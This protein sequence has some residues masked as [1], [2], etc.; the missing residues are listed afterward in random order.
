LQS[1]ATVEFRDEVAAELVERGERE[2][3][4]A[5]ELVVERGEFVTGVAEAAELGGECFRIERAFG[6]G[7]EG[8]GGAGRISFAFD[9]HRPPLQSG[10]FPVCR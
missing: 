7:L 1:A 8:D 5:F 6:G 2:V 10:G 9:G 3:A 4:V